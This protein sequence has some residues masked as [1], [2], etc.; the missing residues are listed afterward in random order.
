MALSFGRVAL[1]AAYQLQAQFFRQD[2]D[3]EGTRSF[4]ANGRTRK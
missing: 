4:A 1:S 3:L 2:L